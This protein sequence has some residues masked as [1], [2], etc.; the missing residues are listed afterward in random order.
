MAKWFA[1]FGSFDKEKNDDELIML[2]SMKNELR[3]S[4][5]SSIDCEL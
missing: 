2:K 5:I 3:Q 1:G 4:T